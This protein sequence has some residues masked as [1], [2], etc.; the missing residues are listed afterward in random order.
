MDDFQP[1]DELKPDTSD[2]PASRAKKPATASKLPISKQ[3]VMIA[4]GILVL[5]LLVLGIG[6][7]LNGSSTPAQPAAQGNERNIDLSGNGDA[8]TNSA[9]TSPA[10]QPTQNE[11]NTEQPSNPSSNAT[12]PASSSDTSA[13]LA[14]ENGNGAAAQTTSVTLPTGPAV[15]DRNAKLSKSGNQSSATTQPTAPETNSSTVHHVPAP[16]RHARPKTETPRP[17]TRQPVEHSAPAH[18]QPVHREPIHREPVHREASKAE[19]SV[20]H[21]RPAEVT[22]TPKTTA[23]TDST[24][25]QV[26]TPAPAATTAPVTGKGYTL[27]LSSASRE[28]TLNAWAKQ[29]NL[30]GY[31]V[32]KTERNGQPWYV[33]VSGSYKT[34]AEAKSAIASLPDAVKAKSPWVKPL[35]QLH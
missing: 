29:Q 9:Q 13:P 24:P 15:L 11:P 18:T 12:T 22:T 10:A 20:A 27:Q 34:P 14:Q 33:L 31:R 19:P 16:V 26:A 32:Y 25:A 6:S 8:S 1:E 7:A 21:K 5:L 23:R 2:R 30:S 4:V 17:Q 3:H 35:S 28:D